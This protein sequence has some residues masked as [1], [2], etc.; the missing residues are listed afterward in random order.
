LK[1]QLLVVREYVHPLIWDHLKQ[2]KD[3][4]IA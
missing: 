3:A 1:V 4:N 2:I